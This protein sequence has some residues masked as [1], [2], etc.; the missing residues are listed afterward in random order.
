M[1]IISVVPVNANAQISNFRKSSSAIKGISERFN[2]VSYSHNIHSS[3]TA[4]DIGLSEFK[5]SIT[6]L[7]NG[8]STSISFRD[9]FQQYSSSSS[10]NDTREQRISDAFRIGE[11]LLLSTDNVRP[12]SG[13][14]SSI[15]SNDN[16]S[17][18]PYIENNECASA[19]GTS[20]RHINDDIYLKKIPNE[21]LADES[22]FEDYSYKRGKT[23]RTKQNSSAKRAKE[24][25]EQLAAIE[26]QEQLVGQFAAISAGQFGERSPACMA[27]SVQSSKPI[28]FD[29]PSKKSLSYIGQGAGIDDQQT[30]LTDH[31]TNTLNTCNYPLYEL[32]N[33]SY[34]SSAKSNNSRVGLL[35]SQNNN[36]IVN[37]MATTS[38]M[39]RSHKMPLVI[40]KMDKHAKSKPNSNFIH[41]ETP[42]ISTTEQLT[43]NAVSCNLQK[44]PR[45]SEKTVTNY[46]ERPTHS[47][48]LAELTSNENTLTSIYGRIYRTAAKITDQAEQLKKVTKI[49]F[50]DK[51]S[52]TLRENGFE[53][54]CAPPVTP[55]PDALRTHEY[56]PSMSDIRSQR[57]VKIRLQ[58]LEKKHLK[59]QEKEKGT[60]A[61]IEQKQLKDKEKQL[62]ANQRREIYALNKVMT[63]LENERFLE[64][65][66]AKSFK[67]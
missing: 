7:Q 52:G 62:K 4:S 34:S 20:N 31:L 22:T 12:K 35:T 3:H 44:L 13:R 67:I 40:V 64:F 42:E 30:N 55:T 41:K 65:C 18:I 16:S 24:N 19:C 32:T 60:L 51:Q 37:N 48:H 2:T 50:S 27:S 45:R 46:R 17:A 10:N 43:L 36:S 14:K 56:I 61:K 1:S 59:K 66:Q 26:N 29:Q 53:F 28:L 5:P 15:A 11:R 21:E 39:V 63:E 9:I 25:H 6:D 8:C 57:T 54:P 49:Y 58:A 33:S 47:G 23:S 38:N